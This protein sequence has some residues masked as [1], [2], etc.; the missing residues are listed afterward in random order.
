M[1][2][3]RL[4]FK[5]IGIPGVI[6]EQGLAHVLK[7]QTIMS[8]VLFLFLTNVAGMVNVYINVQYSALSSSGF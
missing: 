8:K 5:Q 3:Y 1:L 6:K 7:M 4:Q 2:H